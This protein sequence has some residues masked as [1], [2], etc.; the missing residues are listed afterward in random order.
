M[1]TTGIGA[2]QFSAPSVAT[3]LDRAMQATGPVDFHSKVSASDAIGRKLSIRLMQRL[4][5]SLGYPFSTDEVPE[6]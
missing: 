3:D 5:E 6:S 4:L 2:A 1:Q